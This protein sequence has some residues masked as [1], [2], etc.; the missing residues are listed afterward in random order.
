MQ[1]GADLE[2]AWF[3]PVATAATRKR[4]LRAALNEVVTVRDAGLGAITRAVE[5]ETPEHPFKQRNVIMRVGEPADLAG[6]TF[7]AN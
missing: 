1:L 3:H 7:I 5:V 4:I 2:L 6:V